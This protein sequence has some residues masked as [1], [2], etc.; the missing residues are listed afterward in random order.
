MYN[1]DQ[2]LFSSFIFIGL[3]VFCY[4]YFSH[5]KIEDKGNYYLAE[6]IRINCTS[7][8]V[9]SEIQ[10]KYNSKKYTV[11]IPNGECKNY[12]Q[13]QYITLL[14]NKN[15][16]YFFINGKSKKNLTSIYITIGALILSLIPWKSLKTKV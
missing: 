7:R 13:K 4:F 5:K 9:G 14:Y 3:L 11:S 6:I 1:K 2:I 16:D 12:E 10:V 8:K 15:L